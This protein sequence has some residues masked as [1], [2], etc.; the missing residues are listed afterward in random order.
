ML[1]HI[2][3][4]LRQETIPVKWQKGDILIVDNILAAHG[5]MPF[6]GARRIVLAM[7]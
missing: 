3:E 7:T 1:E 4:V 5:R 6:S 2:R